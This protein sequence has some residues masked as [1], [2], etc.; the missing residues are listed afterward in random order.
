MNIK[1][2]TISVIS[3]K[4]DT[5]TASLGE[6]LSDDQPKVMDEVEFTVLTVSQRYS[7]DLI[8]FLLAPA[9]MFL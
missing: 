2:E 7:Y 4:H 3:K 9:I 8:F 1:D 6:Y 5:L